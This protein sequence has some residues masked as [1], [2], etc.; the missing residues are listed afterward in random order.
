MGYCEKVAVFLVAVPVRITLM[1]ISK[2]STAKCIFNE[3]LS[4]PVEK[5]MGSVLPSL[6]SYQALLV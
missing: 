1:G 5:Q 4:E 6:H 3:K 2:M